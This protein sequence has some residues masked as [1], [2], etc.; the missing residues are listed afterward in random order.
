VIDQ[1]FAIAIKDVKEYLASRTL[2]LTVFVLPV[3]MAVTIPSLVGLFLGTVPGS[4]A[5][6][7]TRFMPP[8]LRQAVEQLGPKAGIYWYLY[9]VVTLP[10]FLLM[11][12][13][14]ALVL[15]TFLTPLFG[16]EIGRA[17]V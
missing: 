13:A 3:M 16:S 2:L 17:H 7:D 1:V 15:V 5:F 8:V 4:L 10:L 14:A 6:Q 11:P 12:T 9:T